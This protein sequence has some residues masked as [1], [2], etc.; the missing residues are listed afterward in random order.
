MILA[1]H[2]YLRR[3][4]L[5]RS[6]KCVWIH[7]VWLCWC[8]LTVINNKQTCSIFIRYSQTYPFLISQFIKETDASC[9]WNSYYIL[10]QKLQIVFISYSICN[11]S[12]N[13][14]LYHSRAL[15]T[16]H[17]SLVKS[18]SLCDNMQIIPSKLTSHSTQQIP[19]LPEN[20]EF[21]NICE[22]TIPF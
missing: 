18:F 4:S 22:I 21:L 14:F 10:V 2:R 19:K 12:G 6:Q 7:H 15:A 13:F 20:T 11:G 5:N 1:L 17:I 3:E 9:L 8:R 16:F